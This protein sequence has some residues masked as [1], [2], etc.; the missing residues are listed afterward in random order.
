M[1]IKNE[2]IQI[3]VEEIKEHRDNFLLFSPLN[4]HLNTELKENIRAHGILQPILI[5]EELTIICGHNRW[6]IAKELDYS[7]A[8]CQVVYGSQSE[9]MQLMIS[10]NSLRRGTEKNILRLI[11]QAYQLS[12]TG[13]IRDG[14]T[15]MGITKSKFERYRKLYNLS[16]EFKNLLVCNKLTMGAGYELA[17][18]DM[19]TQKKYYQQL[20]HLPKINENHVKY[21]EEDSHVKEAQSWLDLKKKI[22]KQNKRYLS[23]IEY[24][25]NLFR[26][27]KR[28]H[29]AQVFIKQLTTL[30][31]DYDLRED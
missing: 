3:P 11:E 2:V 13:T 12:Q 18:I 22:Q 14:A 30:I 25:F 31:T 15:T 21:I 29:D 16:D 10:D 9:L 8:P 26:D 23:E 19:E 1:K 17:T 5:T 20:A 6:R 7:S 28:K 27:N 4:E 24:L